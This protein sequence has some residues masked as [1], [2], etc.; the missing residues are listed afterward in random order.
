M[1]EKDENSSNRIDE[2][3]NRISSLININQNQDERMGYL[4]RINDIYTNIIHLQ[5]ESRNFYKS[6]YQ[7]KCIENIE[8]MDENIQ[9]LDTNSRLQRI[10]DL[11][12]QFYN[13]S[14]EFLNR[15]RD[16]SI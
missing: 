11:Y 1:E 2:L 8:L 6:R 5:G 13:T 12:S 4:N 3:Q 15:I 16:E 10:N 14:S 7:S 9:M